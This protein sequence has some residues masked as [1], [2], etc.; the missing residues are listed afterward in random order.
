M[1]ISKLVAMTREHANA[2]MER[3]LQTTSLYYLSRDLA[4]A[5]DIQTI[6]EA[7][8]RD[9]GENINA[10][11]AV[12]LPEG[13]T[14]AVKGA[15]RDLRLNEKELA[16]ADWA[17]RNRRAAGRGTETLGSSALLYLPMQTPSKTFGVLGVR[18]RDDAGYTNTQNRRLLD[19]FVSQTTLAIERVHL[20]KRAEDIHLDHARE[21]LERA[22]LNSVSHDLRTPMVSITGALGSLRDEGN[23]LGDEARRKLIEAAWDEAGRLNRFVGNLLDMTRLE[24]GAL[25][26]REEPCDVQDLI[27]CA[28]AAVEQRLA[29]K[30]VDIRLQDDLPLVKMDMVL[31]TQV[32]VNLLDNAMKYSPPGSGIEIAARIAGPKLTIEV[33]DRGQGVPTGD[34]AKI[35]DKFYRLPVPEGAG[36]TGLGLAICKGIVEAH[37][38]DI[39]AENREGGGLQIII[40]LPAKG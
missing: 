9:I 36:G 39:R 34:L 4:T 7:V 27:G 11:I 18:L 5:G 6:I 2:V 14:L 37:G 26:P 20:V 29:E 22:L 40:N 1:V 19:A 33:S 35:F 21:S 38:G 15:S 31:M 28:L 10:G 24:S 3:E 25:K 17:F 23:M 32:L 13:D 12:I 30:K 16:V 8:I